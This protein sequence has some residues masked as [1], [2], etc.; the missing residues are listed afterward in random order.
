MEILE[1]KSTITEISNSLEGL[2]VFQLEQ[3]RTSRLE[4]S[5]IEIMQAET[6]QIKNEENR[7]ESL[8]NVGHHQ[9]YQHRSNEKRE[10]K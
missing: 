1:L 10:R 9:V 3:E 4:D 2:S 6:G 5:S 8:R 7:T